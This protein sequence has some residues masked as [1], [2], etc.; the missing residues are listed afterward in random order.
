[1]RKAVL[2][3]I[4]VFL[5]RMTSGAI[6]FDKWDPLSGQALAMQECPKEPGA[7]AVY[8]F[9]HAEVN[10]GYLL[11]H[12]AV[13]ILNEAG[14]EVANAELPESADKL[15]ARTVK[16][17]GTV[18]EIEK[19]DILKQLVAKG[20]GGKTTQ[21]VFPF[22]GVEVGCVLEYKYRRPIGYY[23]SY[24]FSWPF[25]TGLFCLDCRL[26]LDRQEVRGYNRFAL[27]P[28]NQAGIRQD[29]GEKLI[30]YQGLDVPA[31]R[32]EDF[33]P[34][35]EETRATFLMFLATQVVKG[36]S[37][38]DLETTAGREQY[39]RLFWEQHCRERA[40]Y[41]RNQL[42][43]KPEIR[44]LKDRILT[45]LKPGEDPAR[46]IYDYVCANFRNTSFET[47]SEEQ[48]TAEKTE[49]RT[50][51]KEN[52]SIV[53]TIKRGYGDAGDITLLCTALLRAA[54][55][56]AWIVEVNGRDE[57]CFWEALLYDQFEGAMLA[58]GH[59]GQFQFL[60]PGSLHGQFGQ[61][62]WAKQGTT[63]ILF[64]D[65]TGEFIQTPIA[66]AESNTVRRVL[67][68]TI[69][70]R[71]LIGRLR[72]EFSGN[73][74]QER[75]N[76]LDDVTE[77]ERRDFVKNYLKGDFPNVEIQKYEYQNLREIGRQ[78]VITAEFT[79]P[80]ALTETRTRKMLQPILFGGQENRFF[81]AEK[82]V[83]PLS[84]PYEYT[85]IDEITIP[86]PDGYQWEALP[87]FPQLTQPVG[88]YQAQSKQE[89][90]T[91]SLRRTFT[92]HGLLYRET[93]YPHIRAFFE[94]CRKADRTTLVLKKVEN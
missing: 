83:F 47:R 87:T 8:L 63:A 15:K 10:D 5:G 21:K 37:S 77:D 51:Y 72:L 18:M 20:Q 92:R 73:P 50:G 4:C 49:G 39:V 82:R 68:L 80:D 40:K 30:T 84:F 56:E 29:E 17:D 55:L 23:E 62:A 76:R 26:T 44:Q 7:M 48:R 75:C 66:A 59:D 42:K 31:A 89:G 54:G 65:E 2:L 70:G 64:K 9:R 86:A 19:S 69:D 57:R 6:S 32:V 34:P 36:A 53:D 22:P 67:E 61:I 35:D 33:A 12:D 16:K 58:C 71:N 11:V 94:A 28:Y 74:N 24:V 45:G 27:D 81:T 91:L 90:A 1:M 41:F 93:A 52:K 78:L 46:T 14:K 25:Q 13:K 88:Q 79:I 43:L 3:G 85:V 60:D 38:L